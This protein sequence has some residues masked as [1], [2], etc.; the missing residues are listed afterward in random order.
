MTAAV[1]ACED[2]LGNKEDKL[3]PEDVVLR[4]RKVIAFFE[5]TAQQFSE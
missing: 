3:N 5:Q 2:W 1:I 4:L